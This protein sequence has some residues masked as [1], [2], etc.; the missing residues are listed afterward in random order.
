MLFF[1][2]FVGY[3]DEYGFSVHE[4][5]PL[6]TGNKTQLCAQHC[7]C[8]KREVDLD[9][10]VGYQSSPVALLAEAKEVFEIHYCFYNWKN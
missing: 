2:V 10:V 9:R 8:P 4:C 3:L 5:I 7:I 1:D 6:D